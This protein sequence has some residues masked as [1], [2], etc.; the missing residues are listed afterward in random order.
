MPGLDVR[1]GEGGGREVRGLPLSQKGLGALAW[2]LRTVGG[3]ESAPPKPTGA[4]SPAAAPSG[5]SAGCSSHSAGKESIGHC[6]LRAAGQLGQ[7]LQDPASISGNR[8]APGTW[9]GSAVS[10]GPAAP[11]PGCGGEQG[12]PRLLALAGDLQAVA[13][14]RAHRVSRGS[15]R[16]LSV[17]EKA[18]VSEDVGV[19]LLGQM[20]RASSSANG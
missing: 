15:W 8:S 14:R 3:G 1:R 18:T 5:G 2:S 19:Q 17:P 10:S 6:D 13:V 4:G 20:A 9:G 16:Y 12:A 7:P 11:A